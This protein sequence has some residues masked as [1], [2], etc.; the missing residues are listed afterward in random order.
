MEEQA[1]KREE[2]RERE[3]GEET[4]FSFDAVSIPASNQSIPFSAE[5]PLGIDFRLAA[6]SADN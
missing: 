3:G 2:E 5:R 1:S 6:R 4:Q